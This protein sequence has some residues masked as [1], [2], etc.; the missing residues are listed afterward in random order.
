MQ[1]KS[2]SCHEVPLGIYIHTPFCVERCH[3]C[4]YRAFADPT[5]ATIDRYLDALTKELR[6]YAQLPAVVGR[7]P[8]F[9]YFG[10]GTPSLMT[11]DQIERLLGEMQN[12]FSWDHVQEA[13]FE[14]APLTVTP[15]RLK[16]LRDA[17]ITRVSMGVQ[18][19]DDEVL[20][21]NGRVHLVDDVERAY[22]EIRRCDFDIVNLDLMIGLVGETDASF[23]SSL[24]RVIRMQAQSVTLYQLEVPMNTPLYRDMQNDNVESPLAGWGE[25]RERLKAGFA[26]LEQSDNLLNGD[27]V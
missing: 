17:G 22:D 4:Y 26:R 14:C 7:Q 8:S 6:L 18:Q 5:R 11:A 13:T 2:A 20:T 21:K 1:A 12:I 19:L 3:F 15:D 27:D 9:V 16:V 24:D 23:H 10:G 25:R